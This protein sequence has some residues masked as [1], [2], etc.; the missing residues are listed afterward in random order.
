MSDPASSPKFP[1]SALIAA[2]RRLPGMTQ[3]MAAEVAGR[4]SRNAPER[5]L[6]LT[7]MITTATELP[8]LCS[9]CH[10]LSL[11]NPCVIC[12]DATRERHRLRVVE[13]PLDVFALESLGAYRG[14]YHVLGGVIAPLDGVGPDDLRIAEL[15]LRVEHDAPAIKE[16]II[17]T[18]D[19][20][21]GNATAMYLWKG[22]LP[23]RCK[24]S[25]DS[26][27]LPPLR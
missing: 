24:V 19:D 5:A 1:L 9:R 16:I 27:G 12:R 23:Y 11:D 17:A 26:T 15:L 3:G 4:L 21:P 10:N 6:A 18:R 7:R 2:L 8:K 22:V 20:I 25:R 14:L 13:E